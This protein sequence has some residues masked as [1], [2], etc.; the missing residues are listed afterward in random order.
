M[1]KA[2]PPR[3]GEVSHGPVSARINQVEPGH[4]YLYN[5]SVHPD[6][7]GQGIGTQFMQDI[8]TEHDKAR[9]R[10]TLHTARPELV[11]WYSRMGFESEGEDVLGTR[12]TR[13]PR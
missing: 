1:P 5:L 6:L 11:K 9:S 2:P 13:R 4:H 3:T 8:I 10:L 7:R 12:M